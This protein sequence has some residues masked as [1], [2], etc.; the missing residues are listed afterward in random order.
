MNTRLKTEF[1]RLLIKLSDTDTNLNYDI[2]VYD[3]LEYII[4]FCEKES[5]PFRVYRFLKQLEAELKFRDKSFQ[6]SLCTIMEKLLFLIHAEQRLIEFQIEHPGSLIL[7]NKP[8][9]HPKLLK[10]TDDKIALVEL[11]YA[12][13]KSVNYGKASIKS[14]AECFQYFFQVDLGSYYRI[15][16]DINN[17]KTDVSRYLDSLPGH[18]NECLKKLNQ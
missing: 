17:R 11:I 15:F 13:S 10:W 18:L 2:I 3:F 4:D 16:L 7:S 14:I 12:I 6:S 8:T 1:D 9:Q 5:N